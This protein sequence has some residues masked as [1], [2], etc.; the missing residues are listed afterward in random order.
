MA[1]STFLISVVVI[2]TLAPLG[3]GEPSASP[4]QISSALECTEDHSVPNS[5]EAVVYAHLDWAGSDVTGYTGP[6]PDFWTPVDFVRVP[7]GAPV[8]DPTRWDG[9]APPD[10][11]PAPVGD[12]YCQLLSDGGLPGASGLGPNVGAPAGP[13]VPTKPAN[14]CAE[15]KGVFDFQGRKDAYGP[16]YTGEG[17]Y[18]F[19]FGA[20]VLNNAVPDW[21]LPTNETSSELDA[22][23]TVC[24]DPAYNTYQKAV[25][26]GVNCKAVEGARGGACRNVAVCM[27]QVLTRENVTA[28]TRAFPINPSTGHMVVEVWFYPP[29]P[30]QWL[31]FDPSQNPRHYWELN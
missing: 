28:R 3:C 12:S 5:P 9:I 20:L 2:G 31:V 13:F 15:P 24:S 7:C 19:G 16:E 30:G 26:A 21:T 1:R 23:A 8:G 27:Q 10:Q 4:G 17:T 6:I 18:F 22:I 14:S 25:C 11:E 29:A